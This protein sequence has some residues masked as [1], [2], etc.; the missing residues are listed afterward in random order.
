[1]SKREMLLEEIYK[2]MLDIEYLGQGKFKHKHY[3][4]M[5]SF[6]KSSIAKYSLDWSEDIIRDECYFVIWKAI[7]KFEHDYTIGELELLLK[8][9][10][11]SDTEG[12]KQELRI[13]LNSLKSYAELNI[14]N[15]LL[16]D[17]RKGK[18]RKM[19]DVF[20][21]ATDFTGIEYLMSHEEFVE[22]K[23]SHFAEWCVE[24]MEQI[25]TPTQLDFMNNIFK[26]QEP[27]ELTKYEA[28]LK[29][30]REYKTRNRIAN[31]FLKYY[32]KEFEGNVRQNELKGAAQRIEMLLNHEDFV[33]ALLDYEEVDYLIDAIYDYV[34]IEDIKKFNKAVKNCEEVPAEVIKAYRVALF[35][36]LKS[37]YQEL[38]C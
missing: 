34:A 38:E 9:M 7:K 27:K 33:N 37:I 22:K 4:I 1:M 29:S 21:E 12:D 18:D 31:R 13:Y 5:S 17:S 20:T 19:L 30:N 11:C 14:R 25:L 28:Q 16:S 10:R 24:N 36:K 15:Y 35:K 6:V 2:E 26:E 32:H 3:H 23:P 8:Q